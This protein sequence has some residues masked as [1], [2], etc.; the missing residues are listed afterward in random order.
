MNKKQEQYMIKAL[1]AINAMFDEDS[2][3]FIGMQELREGDNMTDFMHAL[4]NLAC[5]HVYNRL[6][7]AEEKIL[8]FNHIAN[9]LLFQNLK[10]K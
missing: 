3:N 10:T 2:D 9:R 6:T 4:C 1:S 5:C 7:G 8:S